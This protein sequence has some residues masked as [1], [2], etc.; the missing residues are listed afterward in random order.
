MKSAPMR[1]ACAMPSGR[2]WTWYSSRI[3]N[4]EPSPSSRRNWS[5]SSGV[6][7]MRIS[8]IPDIMSVDSG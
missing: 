5:W 7:M 3:P 1:K 4:W 2:A 8:R 6:V